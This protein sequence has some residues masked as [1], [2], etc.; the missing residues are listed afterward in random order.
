MKGLVV[1]DVLLNS[2]SLLDSDTSQRR[3]PKDVFMARALHQT[4]VCVMMDMKGQL[5]M[6]VSDTMEFIRDDHLQLNVCHLV[7]M[8]EFVK[9]EVFA[10]VMEL[11]IMA[12]SVRHPFLHL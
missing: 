4:F 2:L 9:L 11:D 3:V 1:N 12:P 7:S 10:I 5:V 6:N 8:E